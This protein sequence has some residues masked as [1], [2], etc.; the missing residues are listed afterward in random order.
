MCEMYVKN[1]R[2]KIATLEV[3]FKEKTFP[4]KPR[5]FRAF[6]NRKNSFYLKRNFS[7]STIKNPSRAGKG[8]IVQKGLS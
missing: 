8:R 1:E 3:S 4:L 6:V 5:F 2:Y 7:T